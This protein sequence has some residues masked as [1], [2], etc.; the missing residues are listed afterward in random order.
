MNYEN[1]NQTMYSDPSQVDNAVC[2]ENCENYN[3][4][5]SH[6]TQLQDSFQSFGQIAM[7]R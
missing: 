5:E 4:N 6:F 7:K 1:S 3:N 2:Y